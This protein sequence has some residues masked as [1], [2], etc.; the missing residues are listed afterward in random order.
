MS[1]T[2][3]ATDIKIPFLAGRGLQKIFSGDF[4]FLPFW[5]CGESFYP[6]EIETVSIFEGAESSPRP[7][8][9]GPASF[10]FSPSVKKAQ[11]KHETTFV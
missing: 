1:E 3:I 2:T 9:I 10:S 8:P 6:V 4:S 5:K 11:R 7:N